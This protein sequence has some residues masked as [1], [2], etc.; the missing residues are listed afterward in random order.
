MSFDKESTD[1]DKH[2]AQ[3]R[4][5]VENYYGLDENGSK[6]FCYRDDVLRIAEREQVAL[7]V[8]LDDVFRFDETLS[9][10]I[11]GNARRFHRIFNEVIDE[12]VQEALGG[13]QPP[14]RDALDAFIFQRVHMDDQLKMAEDFMGGSTQEVRK[15]YPPQLLRRF[16]VVFKNRDAMKPLAVR[17]LK[18]N[19]VGKLVTVT[20]IV[21][22]ATEVKP[23]LEVMTY[24]CDTCGAE[25]YQPINGPSFMP[26]VNC[27]SK[28]CVESKANGRLHMQ[29]RGSK[30]NKF[31]E[32][33]IQELS[34]QVPVGSIPRALTVNIYG[35]ATRQCAPGDLVRISGVLIP[36][37]KTGF[38]Q[39][40]GGLVTETFLE[41]HFVENVRCNV[42]DEDLGD[43][44]TE[45]E[46]DLLA[47]DNLYDMLAYSIAPEIYGLTD[48]KKSLLLALVGGVDKNASGMKIRGCLNVLLMGDPGVAK[49][50]LLSYVNRL[51]P[52]S[53][54]T[55]GRGSSGVGLT[56]AVVKDPLS[57]EMT[58]EG[59]A[60]VMEQ[61]TISIAKAGIMT[62]LNARVAIIAAA[63]PAFGRYN[64]KRSI[65]QNIDLPAALLSR[66]DLLWLIQDKPDRDGDKRL[67]S[68]ITYVHMNS[69]QPEVD[70][71]KPVNMR[72][73]RRLIE[74]AQRKNPVVGDALRER[75]VEM[76]VDMRRVSRE[77][78]DSTFAS[79]RLLLSVIRMSTAL[80]R[81]RLSNVVMS[82]DIE[83][84]IRLMQASKDSL[85][86]EMQQQEIRQ[87][88][89][90]RAFAIL[91]ELCI[92]TGDAIT[93][94]SALEACARKGVSEQALQ[95]TIK[96]HEANGVIVVDAQKRIRFTMN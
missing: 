37:L 2:K 25:V 42:D 89:V 67:A 58:L 45:N 93:L 77:S 59:G 16:E 81:L 26:A 38:R 8:N 51:A 73:I 48:V 27:P 96:V 33:R 46:V 72:L 15:K 35:E 39:A 19:C 55:T 68:H 53:Q 24:A 61:Q 75:L 84:A 12:M 65:E 13:R 18:A 92:S 36:L 43:D 62:T 50:Q 94:Q 3:V 49:S 34:D 69:K 23:I 44:L 82:D 63:N 1:Y 76:Y 9:T 57:G 40:G 31:Q 5:F 71:M 83:E 85:R 20:G 17:D 41:A 88:P 14:I 74:V 80:A 87:S 90:D 52:R 95:D 28:D 54:Y 6:V 7:Y 56:A 4:E 21:I 60:L 86:P 66:F 79:P 11:E 64:P 22:R 47:Q 91:R 32:I 30:F 10:L 78:E 70:G 29:V